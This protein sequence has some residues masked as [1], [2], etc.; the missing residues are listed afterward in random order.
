MTGNFN[1][2]TAKVYADDSLLTSNQNISKEVNKVFRLFEYRYDPPTFKHLAV[3]PFGLRNFFMRKINNEIKNA[4][5]G[6]NA[7]LI[8]KVNSLVDK[9]IV[10]KLYEASK[11]G[12]KIQLITRGLCVLIPGIPNLS[13]N[14]EAFSIVDKF[15]EHSRVYIFCNN[16][17]NKYVI[18]SADLM[19]RNLDRRIEVACPVYDKEIQKELRKMLDIQL[20]DNC[21]ARIISKDKPNKYKKSSS[22]EKVRAQV[23]IYKYLKGKL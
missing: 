5:A 4:K 20:S 22:S 23:E 7:W 13:E 17:D 14:I 21:K 2:S 12:V 18:S 11:A 10:N 15:L 9:R 6:K 19:V 8:F 1:E 3:A 16:D